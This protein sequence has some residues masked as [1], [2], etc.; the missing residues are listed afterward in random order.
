M[1]PVLKFNG[2]GKFAGLFYHS[3]HSVMYEEDLY[4]TALHLFEAR[5]FL[6]HRP[7]L[8]ERIRQCERVE[9]VTSMSERLGEFVR[10]DWGN[11]ALSTVSNPFSTRISHC[12]CVR[13]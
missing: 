2:Y 12:V 13:S 9:E 5:K 1:A 10:R 6:Y 8:A 3:P 11:V 4:P 7:D